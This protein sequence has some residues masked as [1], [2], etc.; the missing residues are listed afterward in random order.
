MHEI[1]KTDHDPKHKPFKTSKDTQH[2]QIKDR[3]NFKREKKIS[4]SEAV[5]LCNASGFSLVIHGRR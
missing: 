4:I 2:T 3:Y 5:L 1:I